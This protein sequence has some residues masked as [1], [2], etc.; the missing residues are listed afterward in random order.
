[1]RGGL[2]KRGQMASFIDEGLAPSVRRTLSR[3]QDSVPPMSGG[4][5]A[6]VIALP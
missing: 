6:G 3:L 1:M 5:A 2:R 4:L